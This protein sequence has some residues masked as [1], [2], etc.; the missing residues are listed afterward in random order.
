TFDLSGRDT[1][2]KPATQKQFDQF[3]GLGLTVNQLVTNGSRTCLR[4][5]EHGASMRHKGALASWG[6][7]GLYKWDGE[8]LTENFVEQDYYSRRQQLASGRPKPVET[9]A[10]APW[11]TVAEPVNPAAESVVREVLERGDLTR[12]DGLDFDDAWT[13]SP[14][15]RVLQPD[16]ATIDDLFS[17]GD[18]VAFRIT[19]TGKLLDDFAG[20][21]PRFVNTPVFLHMTGLVTVRDGRIVGGRVIRDRLGLLRRLQA[22]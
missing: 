13:G 7:I 10:L 18:R 11:D 2:Y 20:A 3:P 16:G 1:H 6:G 14:P 19:Q 5:S 17:V 22:D 4:F 9:P 21:E 8:R 15:Q 12:L